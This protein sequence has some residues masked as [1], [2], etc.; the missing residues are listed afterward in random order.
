MT[1][2][3]LFSF[4]S[5]LLFSLESDI[6]IGSF[7]S[8]HSHW[9]A[10]KSTLMK[11]MTGNLEPTE[12]AVFL[13]HHLRIARFHQHLTDQLDL[14]LSPIEWLCHQF[15]G[16][17]PQQMRGIVGRFGLTGKS[18]IVP[19]SQL[20]DGQLRRVVFSWLSQRNAHLL[21]LVSF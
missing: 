3:H 12:G 21:M 10:G 5:A 16:I 7:Y 9:I 6:L 15:S 11:L 13:H 8:G 14:D 2:G 4:H 17:K 20:S 1:R 18:Q 19:M